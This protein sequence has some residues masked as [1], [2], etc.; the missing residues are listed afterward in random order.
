MCPRACRGL[1]QSDPEWGTNLGYLHKKRTGCYL[2]PNQ[3]WMCAEGYTQHCC[4]SQTTHYFWGCGTIRTWWNDKVV[5]NTAWC[6]KGNLQA[7]C[8][9]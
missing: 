7:C 2:E 6:P 4:N 8:P 9:N 3:K 5:D 1:T